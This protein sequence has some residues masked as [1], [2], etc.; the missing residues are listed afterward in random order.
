MKPGYKKYKPRTRVNERIRFFELRIIDSDGK[1]IGVLKRDEALRRAFD[2]G[3]DLVEIV[4]TA[5][6]PICKIMD[7]GKYKYEQHKKDKQ[8]HKSVQTKEIKLG[9]N[10]QEGDIA[11]RMKQAE[12]FLAQGNKIRAK[13]RFRGREIIY[14]NRGK[15]VLLDFAKGLPGAIEQAPRIDGKIMSIVIAPKHDA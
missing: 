7:Y 1:Q 14:A 10:I 6:P 3:L 13:L 2:Q 5:R 15:E 8:K 4:P 11:V 9:L 12:K